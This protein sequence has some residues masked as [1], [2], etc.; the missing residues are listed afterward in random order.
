[1]KIKDIFHIILH[2]KD[3]LDIEFTACS[4]EL[5]PE[6]ALTSSLVCGSGTVTEVIK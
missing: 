1:M 2:L 3:C 6:E 5:M 4:L